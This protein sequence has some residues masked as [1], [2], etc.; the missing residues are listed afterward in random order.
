MTL[1][2]K[3][4]LLGA[5]A[6]ATQALYVPSGSGKMPRHKTGAPKKVKAK[7]KAQKLAR[8]KNR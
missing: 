5:T 2:N 8:R 3:T 1:K 6:I 7:R 4:M